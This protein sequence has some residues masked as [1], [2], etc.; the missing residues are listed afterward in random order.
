MKDNLFE[1][2]INLFEKSLAQLKKTQAKV[3]SEEGLSEEAVDDSEL[4]C[5]KLMNPMS[6][7]ILTLDEQI[8]LTKASYQFLMR[9]KRW[10]VLQPELMEKVLHQLMES[11]SNLVSLEETKWTIRHVMAPYLDKDQLAFLDLVLYRHEDKV[12]IN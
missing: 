3:E 5:V 10:G 1:M 7:R 8:K 9:I 11:D 4:L 12:T 2:L 6:F